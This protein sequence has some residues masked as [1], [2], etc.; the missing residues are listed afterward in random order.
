MITSLPSGR[1]SEIAEAGWNPSLF[2]PDR[3][4]THDTD[5]TLVN[6]SIGTGHV[7]RY[8]WLWNTLNFWLAESLDASPITE[9]PQ[10]E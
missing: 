9:S 7:S 4:V 5:G 10:P 2:L 1:A 3:F 6:T 8:F